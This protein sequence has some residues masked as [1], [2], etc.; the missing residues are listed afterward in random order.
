MYNR[1]G[2]L[3]S[4]AGDVVSLIIVVG[5]AALVLVFVSVLGGAA[6]QQT[7]TTIDTISDSN[8]KADVTAAAQSG[9]EAMK[10]TGEWL[11]IIVMAIVISIVLGL[12]VGLGSSRGPAGGAL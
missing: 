5:I 7:E 8:V 12:V 3:G 6:Y 4:Q 2:Y 10:V 9:F 1:E 11:P